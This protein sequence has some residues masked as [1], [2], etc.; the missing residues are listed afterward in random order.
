MSGSSLSAISRLFRRNGWGFPVLCGFGMCVLQTLVAL[1]RF[2]G[3]SSL[4]RFPDTTMWMSLGLFFVTGGLIGILIQR[5]LRGTTSGF[6]IL[7]LLATILATPVAVWL[8]L[9]GG[10]F[11]P[12]GVLI[13]G[14]LPYL[15][16]VGIVRLIGKLW[17]K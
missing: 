6:R 17:A 13:Y 2:G 4:F 15:L 8:S 16:L 3:E 11:G 7:L 12:L 1:Y 9:I 5:L 14:I 10:L